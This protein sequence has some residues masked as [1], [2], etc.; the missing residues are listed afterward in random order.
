VYPVG[1]IWNWLT[2]L[3]GI[4]ATVALVRALRMRAG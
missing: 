3:S 1:E 2:T 4:A